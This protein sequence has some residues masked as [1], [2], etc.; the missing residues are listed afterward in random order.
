MVP[1][2]DISGGDGQY[3]WIEEEGHGNG[4]EPCGEGDDGGVAGSGFGGALG[5]VE[6]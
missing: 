3:K 6:R 1:P 2:L 4:G 5:R